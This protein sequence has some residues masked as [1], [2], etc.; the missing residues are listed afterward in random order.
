MAYDFSSLK[1]N[2]EEIKSWLIKEFSGIRTG[3]A[4][5]A[6]LDG[7]LVEAYGSRTP[8]N[9]IASVTVEDARTLR[10]SPWDASIAK[11]V[12]KAL[13]STDL[14]VSVSSDDRGCRVS[15]PELTAERREQ[16]VKKVKETLEDA[17]IRLRT[18]RDE[19]WSDIQKQE[20]NGDI[21][22][23]EK[24]KYKEDMQK[25]VDEGN[26]ALEVLADKKEKEMM[27]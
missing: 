16:L 19:V 22:E 20:K 11:D 8:I 12:E 27:N 13:V 2:I 24:F 1:Q 14:G 25:V 10:V 6:L 15:F 18:E 17:R 21:T 9:Q 5:P 4:A 23:D 3:R 26:K 7:V